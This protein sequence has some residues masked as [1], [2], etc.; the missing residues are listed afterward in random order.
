MKVVMIS[1][2]R[3]PAGQTAT[4]AK[5]VLE[6]LAEGKSDMQIAE[7]LQV[8]ATTIAGDCQS[9]MRKLSLGEQTELVRYAVRRCGCAVA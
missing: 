6:G 1:G 5:A 8:P 4:A 2:S 3:N 9:L 7:A